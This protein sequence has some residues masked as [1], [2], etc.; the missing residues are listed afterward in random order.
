MLLITAI[1]IR[2]LEIGILTI[3]APKND[4]TNLTCYMILNFHTRQVPN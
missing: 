4:E 1:L 2:I 3:D